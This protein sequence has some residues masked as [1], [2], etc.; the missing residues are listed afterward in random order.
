VTAR[1][2]ELAIR[3]ALGAEPHT[4]LG[5]VVREG[6]LLVVAGCLL[7]ALGAWLGGRSLSGLLYEVAPTDPV[8]MVAVLGAVVTVGLVACLIP[9]RRAS[10]THPIGIL[11]GD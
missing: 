11:R 5:M 10:L 6:L 1:S 3:V 7:G 8:T 2:R 4:V 9:G